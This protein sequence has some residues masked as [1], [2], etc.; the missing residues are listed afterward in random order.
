LRPP[1]LDEMGL[2]PALEFYLKDQA[3][4]AGITMELDT[5]DLD[6]EPGRETQIACFRVVQEAVTNV[7]RHAQ[8]QTLK[9]RLEAIGGDV[10]VTVRD[11][12]SGFVPETT[13]AEAVARGHMGIV[14]IRERVRALGGTFA[15]ESAPGAGTTLRASLPLNPRAELTLRRAAAG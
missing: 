12:G 6:A 5:K 14:G 1:L 2:V 4:V 10:E 13:L 9:V 8:A 7:L 15:I 3:A 11:D